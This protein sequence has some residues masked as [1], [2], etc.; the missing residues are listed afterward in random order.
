MIFVQFRSCL[1]GH[2]GHVPL[3]PTFSGER[4]G[5]PQGIVVFPGTSRSL[6]RIIKGEAVRNAMFCNR[7]GAQLQPE[8]AAC[9]S[10]GKRIGDPVSAVA[11]SRLEGHLRIVGIL[12]IALGA[13]FAIPAAGLLVFGTS[14]HVILQR[15]EFFPG[16]LPLLI[17]IAAG[18]FS[19]LAVGGI[20]VGVGLTQ[21]RPWA[22]VA[23]IVLGVLALFHPLFGTALGIY[24]LWVLLAD[25]NGS[26]YNYLAR[27]N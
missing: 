15:H 10:C 21:R 3:E 17:S 20:C 27:N 19:L 7:C 9:P 2:E 16:I 26:E 13:L 11:Q 1:N 14:V 25:E 18:A 8:F 6:F 4:A 22:R 24:T 12:W 5:R 23:A